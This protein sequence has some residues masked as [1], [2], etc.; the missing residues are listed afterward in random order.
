MPLVYHSDARSE[1]VAPSP[2]TS[3]TLLGSTPHE[4][5]A[6]IRTHGRR[7]RESDVREQG[8][9][10]PAR[11]QTFDVAIVADLHGP[12]RVAQQ[13][14]IVHLVHRVGRIRV[15]H[16]LEVAEPATGSP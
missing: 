13:E 3:A 9:P 2:R 16:P 8:E 12:V 7:G 6:A 1:P 11:E 14:G 4:D 15:R 10:T 5:D